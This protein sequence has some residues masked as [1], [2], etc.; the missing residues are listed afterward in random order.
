[1]TEPNPNWRG[2]VSA[3]WGAHDQKTNNIDI[4]GE[5]R[6]PVRAHAPW[7]RPHRRSSW[8]DDEVAAAALKTR[9]GRGCVAKA[10]PN[11]RC[12]HHGGFINGPTHACWEGAPSGRNEGVVGVVAAKGAAHLH[13]RSSSAE[14]GPGAATTQ[15]G[16]R[17]SEVA[18]KAT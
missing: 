5:F 1:M 9:E 3:V 11:G 2:G 13:A 14:I 7:G 4:V 16:H 8:L 18:N 17:S 12:R 10:L 15:K 6:S